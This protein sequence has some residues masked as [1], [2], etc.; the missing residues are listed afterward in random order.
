MRVRSSLAN[1]EELPPNRPGDDALQVI[2]ETPR[3]SRNKYNFDPEQRI[4]TLRKVLPAG[5]A[6]PYDFGFLPGT[7]GGDGD[8]L[9]V[10]V[11]MDEPAV[12]GC[13]VPVR[14]IGVIEAEQREGRK[15]VRNDRLLAVAQ[16]THLYAN[17]Y[18]YTD[19]PDRIVREIGEFFVNYHRLEGS[20]YRTLGCKGPSQATALV[21]RSKSSS[22][23]E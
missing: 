5:M 22:A 7:S 18:S 17:V 15:R 6:F 1:P 11:L 23:K 12:P 3:G 13:L 16:A 21:R 10:L 20:D 2:I 19:L 9:D 4:F 14:L 8:P